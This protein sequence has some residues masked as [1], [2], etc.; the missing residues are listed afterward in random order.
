MKCRIT[1]HRQARIT[2]S[3]F[4][5]LYVSFDLVIIACQHDMIWH[6]ESSYCYNNTYGLDRLNWFCGRQNIWV[7]QIMIVKYMN[8]IG[9]S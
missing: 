2:R 9:I 6:F 7:H 5:A 4:N 1:S 3:N 8:V